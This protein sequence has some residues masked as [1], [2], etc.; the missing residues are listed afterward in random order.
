MTLPQSCHAIVLQDFVK[1]THIVTTK[2]FWI[3]LFQ[4]CIT[5][6]EENWISFWNLN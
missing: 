2:T 3:V 1:A 5:V 6:F 4:L